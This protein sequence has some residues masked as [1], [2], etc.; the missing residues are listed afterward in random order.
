MIGIKILILFILQKKQ[1]KDNIRALK[2]EKKYTIKFSGYHFKKIGREV[3]ND[4]Y[5]FTDL[6]KAIDRNEMEDG[7]E[8]YAPIYSFPKSD[9]WTPAPSKNV[10]LYKK[11]QPKEQ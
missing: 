10:E 3:L 2:N 7:Y 1:A 5:K 4:N 8:D 11:N 6:L 9:Y